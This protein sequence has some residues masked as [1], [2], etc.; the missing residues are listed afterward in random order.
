MLRS[1]GSGFSL[2][3]A[4]IE[5]LSVVGRHGPAIS[6]SPRFEVV[7]HHHRRMV[8]EALDEVDIRVLGRSRDRRCGDVGSRGKERLGAAHGRACCACAASTRMRMPKTRNTRNVTASP[9]D[10]PWPLPEL[11]RA[12]RAIVVVDVVESVRLMQE[13]EAG[14]IER[15]RRFVHE[16][17]TEVLPKH[18]GRLVKSLGDGMLLEFANA[19]SAVMAALDV[20]SRIAHHN[21]TRPTN[22]Q[23]WLR[24][25]L[26]VAD[27]AVDQFDLYGSGVNLAA[28]IAGIASP[29]SVIATADFCEAIVPT[30]DGEIEDLGECHLKHWAQPQRCY[31]IGAALSTASTLPIAELSRGPTLAVLPLSE[32]GV[33]VPHMLGQVSAEEIIR[34]LS[35]S[36]RLQVISRLSTSALGGR[37]FSAQE[38]GRRLSAGYVVSGTL[39][40]A[41]A[42][43]RLNVELAETG[44]GRV[45][46]ADSLTAR[47]D[48]LAAEDEGVFNR[49]AMGISDAIAGIE[50]ARA[51]SLPLPNLDT[52]TL[53]VG[54]VTLMHR[55]GISDFQRARALLEH[56][57]ERAG[58]HPVPRSWLAK[59]HVLN[60]QQGWSPDPHAD[61]RRALDLTARALDTDPACALAHTV[62][63]FA[64]A[65][66]LREFE[67]ADRHYRHAL[68]ANPSDSLAWLLSGMLKAFQ[69]EGAAALEACDQARRLSPLDPLRYFYDALTASAAISAGEYT[70]SVDMA[71]QSLRLN[72]SHLSTHRALTA[73][74]ELAGRHDEAAIAACELLARDPGFTVSAFLARTPGRDYSVSQSVAQALR[75]AGVPP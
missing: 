16:V 19:P 28:R 43:V 70:R 35:R 64:H 48:D 24:A 12:R 74:L 9:T 18:G 30:L 41:G 7:I 56:L 6:D 29:G 57:T 39:L 62:A 34:L 15:W 20:Q 5:Q 17:R 47:P 67:Q 75:A 32:A 63:G 14:F 26:N 25:G 21:A 65:N 60:V 33:D 61:A 73:A 53:M 8:R 51:V 36:D 1:P 52:Y 27:V 10:A 69:G 50:L 45:V 3:S 42:H 2:A 46:W 59:W 13:D 49:I 58:R 37:A 72:R 38:V 11:T 31:R 23:L 4:R 54:G 55:T 68:D 66:V 22:E 40:S 44:E 71:S